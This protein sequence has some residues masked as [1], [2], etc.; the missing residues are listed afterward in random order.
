MEITG[1]DKINKL[2]N[3]KDVKVTSVNA[4]SVNS[5]NPVVSKSANATLEKDGTSLNASKGRIP[6]SG[7]LLSD[8]DTP[9]YV[10]KAE[11]ALQVYGG[12]SRKL[13][14]INAALEKLNLN[15]GIDNLSDEDMMAFMMLGIDLEMDHHGQ[16]IIRE[17]NSG[18]EIKPEDFAKLQTN[19]ASSAKRAIANAVNN[20]A[21][22]S[23]NLNIIGTITIDSKAQEALINVLKDYQKNSQYNQEVVEPKNKELEANIQKYESLIG[24]LEKQTN[25]IDNSIS[26]IVSLKTQADA[27]MGKAKTGTISEI[28]KKQLLNLASVL[29]LKQKEL[30][31][32]QKDSELL[33]NQAEQTFA[34]F[35]PN[36][37]DGERNTKELIQSTLKAKVSGQALTIEQ[38]GIDNIVKEIYKRTAGMGESQIAEL[39][40]DKDARLK[41]MAD[42]NKFFE[43]L[44]SAT[45][46][47]DLSSSDIETLNKDYHINAVE[48]NGKLGLYYQADDKTTPVKV[49]QEDIRNIRTHLNNMVNSPELFQMGRAAGQISLAYD[50]DKLNRKTVEAA[51]EQA[52]TTK[53]KAKNDIDPEPAKKEKTSNPGALS[54]EIDQKKSKWTEQA[55]LDKSI[56][57]KREEELYHEKMINNIHENRRE[58][59]KYLEKKRVQEHT[60]KELNK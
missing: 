40:D 35:A 15:E 3:E 53:N 39:M 54:E 37:P 60:E 5:E 4:V 51:I 43:R 56:E 19:L 47:S 8:A 20:P 44:S 57:R 22:K 38:T 31:N 34:Q 25:K 21:V 14:L 17:I 18:N 59:N 11:H 52:N 12:D 13:E 26:Q 30:A 27:L 23:A 29:E 50:N 45:K 10:K 6:A 33:M 28:E 1:N 9:S 7:F 36:L 32:N 55:N 2:A 46:L 49:T 42:M 48:E 58:I 24:D 16:V 41:L